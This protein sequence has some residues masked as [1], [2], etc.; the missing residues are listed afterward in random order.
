MRFALWAGHR[1]SVFSHTSLVRSSQ[2]RQERTFRLCA[3][4]LLLCVQ[5]VYDEVLL[6]M[7]GTLRARVVESDR[8]CG[9][10]VRVHTTPG[11]LQVN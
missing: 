8:S 11:G 5:R 7:V 3:S 1:T 10:D 6:R 9:V 4:S 2:E